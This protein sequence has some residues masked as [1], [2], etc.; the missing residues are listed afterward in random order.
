MNAERPWRHWTPVMLGQH[1]PLQLQQQ[2]LPLE[3][4]LQRHGLLLLQQQQQLPPKAQQL[5]LS[6]KHRV[7]VWQALPQQHRWKLMQM[8]VLLVLSQILLQHQVQF[9][10]NLLRERR[11]C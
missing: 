3:N 9:F 8:L 5:L 4:Q 6:Q 7:Q 10:I 2:Q 11:Q 1:W